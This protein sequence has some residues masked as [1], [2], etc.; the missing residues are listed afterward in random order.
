MFTLYC[1]DQLPN[2]RIL[3]FNDFPAP[4]A[5]QMLV[6][7]RL[8]N[9]VIATN[10]TQPHLINQFEFLEEVKG[11]VYRRWTYRLISGTGTTIKLLGVNMLFSIAQEFQK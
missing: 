10:L 1:L 11:A 6:L 4:L 5:D 8:L 7:R 9:L 2:E 3:K